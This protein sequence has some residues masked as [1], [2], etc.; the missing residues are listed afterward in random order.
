MHTTIASI[1][2]NSLLSHAPRVV[3]AEGDSQVTASQHVEQMHTLM[4]QISELHNVQPGDRV[5]VALPTCHKYVQLWHLALLGNFTIVPLNI[6]LSAGELA[7]ILDDCEP[8]LLIIDDSTSSLI[9]E[10][11]RVAKAVPETVHVGDLVG[12]TA[13]STMDNDLLPDEA[14][15]AAILYTGGT[16]GL[17]KG[18]MMSQH[19]LA[20]T[21]MRMHMQWKMTSPAIRLYATTALYHVSG[22]NL[23]LG[24]VLSG[25]LCILVPAFD[26]PKLIAD[27]DTHKVT[28]LVLVPTMIEMLLNHPDFDARRFKSLESI[29]YGGAPISVKLL[30]RLFA[31]LP[32]VDIQQAYGMTELLGSVTQLSCHEHKHQHGKLQSCGRALVGVR[33]LI[34]DNEGQEVASGKTGEICIA[35]DPLMA[36]YWNNPD[37][38]AEV[39]RDGVYYSGDIGFIDEEGYLYLVDRKKDMIVSG[40]EN[41]YSLEVER[42]LEKL[43]GVAQV[44]VFGIPDERWGEIV[45]AVIVPMPDIEVDQKTLKGQLSDVLASYKQPKSWDIRREPLPISGTNKVQKSVLRDPFWGNSTRGVN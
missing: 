26:I 29:A 19:G 2:Q 38:T 8:R 14:S 6:R 12:E 27:N 15:V 9:V 31:L 7:S 43:P 25:G 21:A 23:V 20:M 13:G 33:L 10:A 3:Y 45:H 35:S 1:L 4:H 11:C 37:Q 42:A 16:T 44:A 17:P 40:G 28:H 41:V 24:P 18:V 22:F 36:G 34:L 39:I 5:A 30:E 32:E